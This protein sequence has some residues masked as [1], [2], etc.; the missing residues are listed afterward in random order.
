MRLPLHIRSEIGASNDRQLGSRYTG[1]QFWS[2]GARDAVRGH[3]LT[4]TTT[5]IASTRQGQAVPG[6]QNITMA[7]P[8][9]SSIPEVA[10]GAPGPRE[11]EEDERSPAGGRSRSAGRRRGSNRRSGPGFRSPRRGTAPAATD[12]RPAGAPRR[13]PRRPGRPQCTA[14]VRSVPHRRGRR[15]PAKALRAARAHA[16]RITRTHTHTHDNHVTTSDVFPCVR[17]T[18]HAGP[19]QPHT[20]LFPSPG[21]ERV[22]VSKHTP[23]AAAHTYPG[24]TLQPDRS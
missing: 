12:R 17:P 8:T 6:R 7:P 1:D 10:S 2:D 15:S 3:V 4:S 22:G 18:F 11:G 19:Y 24:K 21:L 23:A 16:P 9:V 14:G 5:R 13:P 20:H